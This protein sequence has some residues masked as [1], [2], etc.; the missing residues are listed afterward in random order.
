MFGEDVAWEIFSYC[1]KCL[2]YWLLLSM[3]GHK[4]LMN[5]KKIAVNASYSLSQMETRKLPLMVFLL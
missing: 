2:L 4:L 3:G 1:S 5:W